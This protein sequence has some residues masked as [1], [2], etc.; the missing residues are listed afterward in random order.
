MPN[1]QGGKCANCCRQSHPCE[2]D[3]MPY[4]SSA[5]ESNDL[6]TPL[7]GGDP[8]ALNAAPPSEPEVMSL[9]T[10]PRVTNDW[11]FGGLECNTPT[12]ETA[13]NS[14]VAQFKYEFPGSKAVVESVRN[15]RDS[16][17]EIQVARKPPPSASLPSIE[18]LIQGDRNDRSL[19]QGPKRAATQSPSSQRAPKRVRISGVSGQS[20]RAGS[21]M[22]VVD[23]RYDNPDD[24]FD[25]WMNEDTGGIQYSFP[26]RQSSNPADNVT[27]QQS[28]ELTRQAVAG[29]AALPRFSQSSRAQTPASDSSLS[30]IPSIAGSREKTPTRTLFT[31]SSGSTQKGSP[32]QSLSRETTPKPPQGQRHPSLEDMPPAPMIGE[33]QPSLGERTRS[34]RP[35]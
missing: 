30:K 7:Y 3:Y 17:Y 1:F 28:V 9:D 33:F 11:P 25:D 2:W 21:P 22:D 13:V 24:A 15:A 29:L 31:R 32:L 6:T 23:P 18:R 5:S 20:S 35:K 12:S 34:R 8:R 27:V 14:A 26:S 10:A 19:A 16:L 4:S